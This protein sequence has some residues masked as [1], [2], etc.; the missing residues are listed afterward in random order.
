MSHQTYIISLCV[1]RYFGRF[2]VAK[3]VGDHC[4]A[5]RKFARRRGTRKGHP[6]GRSDGLAAGFLPGGRGRIREE[7]IRWAIRLSC[8]W[9]S[10]GSNG[11]GPSGSV[12]AP[13]VWRASGAAEGYP[14]RLFGGE[15]G[16][17][18]VGERLVAARAGDRESGVEPTSPPAKRMVQVQGHRSAG[19]AQVSM[20]GNGWRGTPR[21]AV[22]GQVVPQGPCGRFMGE[23][24][25]VRG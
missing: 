8:G 25:P 7:K 14:G 15:P 23:R 22:L 3:R 16:R 21:Q 5:Q 9:K 11:E 1:V 19:G 4:V 17:W 2:C 20:M 10:I 6:Q 24:V 13:I 18:V 12:G